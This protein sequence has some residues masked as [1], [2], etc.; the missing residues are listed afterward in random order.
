MKKCWFCLIN[1]VEIIFMYG[2]G[3][4]ALGY[5]YCPVKCD[6]LKYLEAKCNGSF[7]TASHDCTLHFES[8]MAGSTKLPL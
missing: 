6:R 4:Q 5:K 3:M 8:L 7:L 1:L 2:Y